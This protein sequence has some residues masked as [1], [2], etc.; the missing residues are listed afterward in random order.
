MNNQQ[1]LKGYAKSYFE[2]IKTESIRNSNAGI[3]QTTNSLSKGISQ[4]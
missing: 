2:D 1:N 3:N 4:C